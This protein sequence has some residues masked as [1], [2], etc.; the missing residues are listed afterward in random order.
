VFDRA[1]AEFSAVYADQNEKDF[2]ALQNAV[3]TG[4]LAAHTGV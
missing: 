4:R 2:A 3:K 1:I